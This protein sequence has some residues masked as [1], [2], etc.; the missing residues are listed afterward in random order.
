MPTNLLT[1]NQTKKLKKLGIN[2]TIDLILY[3]PNKYNDQTIIQSIQ[4]LKIGEISQIQAKVNDVE[5][6]YRP[7]KNLITYF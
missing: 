1:E 6:I 3:L 2:S 7:K 5:V 4:N